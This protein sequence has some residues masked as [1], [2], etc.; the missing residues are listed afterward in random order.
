[1]LY[2]ISFLIFPKSKLFSDKATE[3]DGSLE[4][5]ATVSPAAGAAAE[6]VVT[7]AATAAESIVE[8]SAL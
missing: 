1:M 3:V 6:S 8:V 7:G 4:T 5:G 2:F